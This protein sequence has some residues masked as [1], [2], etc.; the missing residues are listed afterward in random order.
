M[1]VQKVVKMMVVSVPLIASGK[2]RAS[3]AWILMHMMFTAV[4]YGWL[5]CKGKPGF[6]FGHLAC[7]THTWTKS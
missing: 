1:T 4:G 3:I 7:G 5:V 6:D 2:W